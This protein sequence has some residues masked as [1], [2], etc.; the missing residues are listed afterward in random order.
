MKHNRKVIF[1]VS[2]H[3][4]GHASR[5]IEII[6]ALTAI[7]P[8]VGVI[9]R[10]SAP[11]WL[12][13]RGT[14][15]PVTFAPG[16]TDTGVVQINSLQVD[17]SAS[18]RLAW[19]FHHTL[20][21]RA[22]EESLLIN[23]CGVTLVVGD[24]PP[25]AFASAALA[26]LPSVAIGNFTWDWIYQHYQNQLSLPPQLLPTIRN[27]YASAELAWE[28]PMSAGFE[29]FPHIIKTPLVARHARRQP[30]D[31]R[32][33]LGLPIEQTLILV[34]FGRYGLNTVDWNTTTRSG[35][36]GIILTRDPVDRGPALPNPEANHRLYS[37]DLPAIAARGFGYEDL[38]A[39][40]DIVISKPGYGIIAECA[41]NDTAL[42][43]T[44]RGDFAEYNVLVENMP[45][46]LKCTYLE[47]N[48]LFAGQWAEAVHRV[49]AQPPVPRPRT[50]GAHIIAQG[51]A[52]Q[53]E[54]GP[55][56]GS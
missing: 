15:T 22:K 45:K 46:L 23:R 13:D 42:I 25:L 40:A 35:D 33:A 34:S 16:E 39:A 31:T 10:T 43:Y 19:Q 14:T 5:Q 55:P 37:I 56:A 6:N 2:G 18:V 24:I 17:P 50:D 1:Y 53:L 20:K 54:S 28:L 8:D 30:A 52:R 51:L 48:N 38:V 49:L 41:A 36:F 11:R 27:A 47:Q 21:E 29:R 26:R 32:K 9:V 12:F 7:C 44:S 3:G 4:F